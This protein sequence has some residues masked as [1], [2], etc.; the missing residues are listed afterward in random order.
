MNRFLKI[1]VITAATLFASLYTLASQ[2]PAPLYAAAIDNCKVIKQIAL[3]EDASK[4][5]H[6]IQSLEDRMD[7]IQMP[8][9]AVELELSQLSLEMEQLS[10][11]AIQETEQTLYIDKELLKEQES[12]ASEISS[13]MSK[14]QG[15]FD[16]LGNYGAQIGKLAEAFSDPVQEAFEDLDY[17]RVRIFKAGESPLD[18]DCEKPQRM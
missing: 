1:S 6:E 7:E 12:L 3:D 15:D 8:L 4:A 16:A 11:L 5:W 18:D 13:L 10:D 17:D 9:Q 14:H 2:A